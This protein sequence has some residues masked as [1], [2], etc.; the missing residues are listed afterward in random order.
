MNM[1]FRYGQWLRL[2][3]ALGAWAV[4]L[5][6]FAALAEG[7]ALAALI[8]LL[9]ALSGLAQP[10]VERL[11]AILGWKLEKLEGQALLL[12]CLG[13]FV[14]L[15]A[16][17]AVTRSWSEVLGLDIKARGERAIRERMTDAFATAGC[18]SRK[19]VQHMTDASQ[20]E[21]VEST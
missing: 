11:W 16:V 20:V 1:L 4:V 3:P 14:L 10:T 13:L 21:S 6:G 15:A 17:A 2:C 8:R 19:P 18:P 9:D 5:A 12:A 7:L